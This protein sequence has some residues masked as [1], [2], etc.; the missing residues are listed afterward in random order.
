MFLTYLTTACVYFVYMG[1]GPFMLLAETE[2]HL[3]SEVVA[4]NLALFTTIYYTID[5]K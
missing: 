1:I 3:V 5:Y 4:D 2:E